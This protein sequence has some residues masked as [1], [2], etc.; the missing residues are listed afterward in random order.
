MNFIIEVE[1]GSGSI[2][3]QDMQIRARYGTKLFFDVQLKG[4]G[5]IPLT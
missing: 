1:K 4:H 5:F 2:R 3:V